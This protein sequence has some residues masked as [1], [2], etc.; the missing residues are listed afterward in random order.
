[1][2]HKETFEYYNVEDE[3]DRLSFSNLPTDN[4][5]QNTSP[6]TGTSSAQIDQLFEFF[7]GFTS[8]SDTNTD[9]TFGKNEG[10]CNE[11]EKRDYLATVETSSFHKASI[12]NNEK[13]SCPVTKNRSNSTRLSNSALDFYQSRSLSGA[14]EYRAQRVNF[15]SLTSMS[16]KSR[17]RMFM[18]GPVKFKPEMELSAIKQRQSRRRDNVNMLPVEGTAVNGGAGGGGK[19]N[20][21][22]WGA[23][24]SLK[25]RSH[26]ATV[27]ARSFGCNPTVGL[28]KLLPVAN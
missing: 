3:E 19:R 21:S 25:C 1:M 15:S 2:E 13:Y 7:T 18:F 12:Y 26:F 11:Y 4:Y 23:L 8:Q 22:Y 16:A 17:R 6:R 27:L 28:E 24:R 20:G 14:S 9:I 10:D 5:E